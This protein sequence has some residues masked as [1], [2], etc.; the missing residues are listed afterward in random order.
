M[1]HT[2]WNRI[3]III[4]YHYLFIISYYSQ[5]MNISVARDEQSECFTLSLTKLILFSYF[6]FLNF[7]KLLRYIYHICIV[8]VFFTQCWSFGPK[9]IYFHNLEIYKNRCEHL[10]ITDN[11]FMIIQIYLYIYRETCCIIQYINYLL[12][13]YIIIYRHAIP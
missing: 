6:W 1:S 7:S 9:T 4:N 13:Y 2:V 10:Y 3:L 11:S 5:Y 8:H 12:Y